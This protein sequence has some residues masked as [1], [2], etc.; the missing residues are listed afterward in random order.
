MIPKLSVP[1]EEKRERKRLRSQR[2]LEK[3]LALMDK[4][5]AERI[6]P[7]VEAVKAKFRERLACRS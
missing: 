1:A 7:D 4:P 6:F 2:S 3:M 5:G